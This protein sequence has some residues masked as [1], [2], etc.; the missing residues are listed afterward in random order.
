VNE[1][2]TINPQLSNLIPALTPDEYQNLEKSIINDGCRDALILWD[3]TIVDGHNRYEICTKHSLEFKTIQQD[4]E[5]IEAAKKWII[6]NQFARRNLSNYQRSI[7]ALQL[8]DIYKKE[9]KTR[10][11]SG[12]KPDPAQ[13]SAGGETRDKVAKK[14][15]VSHDTIDKVKKIEAKASDEIKVQLASGDITI[16]QAY[17]KINT[18]V[19]HNSGENEWYTPLKIIELARLTMGSIDLDPAS[20]ERANQTVKAQKIYT[21]QDSGL[22]QP[23]SGNVW[24]NPPY[25][26]PLISQFSDKLIQELPN[27]CQACVLVNNAT[28]TEWL[29]NMMRNC[30][31]VCF[32]KSRVKFIDKNGNAS[33][34][35][36]QGQV[37]LY[38]GSN[39]DNFYYNFNSLGIC[40]TLLHKNQNQSS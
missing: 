25:G 2:I 30:S 23:W 3:S 15:G 6:I 33:G 28:E 14:A 21:E 16:N 19:G 1:N 13:N 40:F 12:K 34:S 37:I 18:H 11:L 20:C 38:Y 32:I 4:F 27:I 36:L 22:L 9:A 8:E 35:P 39:F 26:Q 10:M 17:K 24:M 29:Q 7:L 5:D 31:A